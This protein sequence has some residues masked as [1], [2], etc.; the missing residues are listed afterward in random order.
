VDCDTRVCVREHYPAD[1]SSEARQVR[2]P[3]CAGQTS[4]AREVR[5][6]REEKGTC[7]LAS[8]IQ[9]RQAEKKGTDQ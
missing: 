8:L 1:R 3:H 4:E 9:G 7:L 6:K 2:L 5:R